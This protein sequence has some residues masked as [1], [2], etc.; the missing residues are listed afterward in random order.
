MCPLGLFSKYAPNPFHHGTT[1]VQDSSCR[2]RALVL[3]VM[4]ING[5]CSCHKILFNGRG[6]HQ[7]YNS[8]I[9]AANVS[10][11]SAKMEMFVYKDAQ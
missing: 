6:T 4:D 1:Q 7:F 8:L 9:K 5:D 2:K 10:V 3:E 11:D